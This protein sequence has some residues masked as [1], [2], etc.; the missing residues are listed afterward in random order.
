VR[1]CRFRLVHQAT[2]IVLDD[3]L[4]SQDER[5]VERYLRQASGM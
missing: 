5:R 2:G 1:W 3:I 4:V